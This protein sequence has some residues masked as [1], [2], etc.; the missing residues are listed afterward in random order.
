MGLGNPITNHLQVRLPSGGCSTSYRNAVRQL[1]GIALLVVGPV[2]AR[3]KR[4]ETRSLDLQNTVYW[5]ESELESSDVVVRKDIDLSPKGRTS[6][7]ASLHDEQP[8]LKRDE[9]LSARTDQA[10]EHRF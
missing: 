3:A 6:H 2:A 10:N 5:P 8:I 4:L 7:E 1:E 9:R